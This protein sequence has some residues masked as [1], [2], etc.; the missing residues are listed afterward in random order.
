[1]KNFD[2]ARK[3]LIDEARG[4]KNTLIGML[5]EGNRDFEALESLF[6]KYV[7][8]LSAADILCEFET[9]EAVREAR[10]AFQ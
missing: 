8:F 5:Q 4:A 7:E 2:A 9:I 3:V 6:R 1:M 10:H